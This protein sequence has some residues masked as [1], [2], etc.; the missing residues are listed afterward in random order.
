MCAGKGRTS[1]FSDSPALE[2]TGRLFLASYALL[3]R[4]V[5]FRMTQLALSKQILFSCIHFHRIIFCCA[6]HPACLCT[7]LLAIIILT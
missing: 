5:C 1:H 2:T 6:R 4:T 7:I 3:E